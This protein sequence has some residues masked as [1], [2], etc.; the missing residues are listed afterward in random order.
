M[1]RVLFDRERQKLSYF[2][3]V[4]RQIGPPRPV[5]T[6]VEGKILVRLCYGLSQLRIHS[7]SFQSASRDGVRSLKLFKLWERGRGARVRLSSSLT[8][9]RAS[10]RYCDRESVSGGYR[11]IEVCATV[12][13]LS[14]AHRGTSLVICSPRRADEQRVRPVSSWKAF[15]EMLHFICDFP[16]KK[17]DPDHLR[18]VRLLREV[19]RT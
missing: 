17:P 8:L 15:H 3:P 6:H 11:T 19:C 9:R 7:V 14:A 1:R 5:H 18:P 2:V 10:C 13:V 4:G 12:P 16:T